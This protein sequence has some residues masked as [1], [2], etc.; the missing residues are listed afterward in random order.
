[1][2]RPTPLSRPA[3]TSCSKLPPHHGESPTTTGIGL[4]AGRKRRVERGGERRCG[5]RS[6][7]CSAS[8]RMPG[9]VGRRRARHGPYRRAQGPR[10][11]QGADRLHRRHQHGRRGGGALCE[12][13]DRK[14]NRRHHAFA[15]LAGRLSRCAPTP[16]SRLQAQ[17]GRPQFP[18][19]CAPGLE[20]R[21]FTS[22]Q[23][24]HPRPTIAGD[25]AAADLAIHRQ[26]EF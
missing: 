7:L 24:V 1:M 10:G 5:D 2:P 23:G 20:A 17:A 14:R 26:R 22:A 18:G 15:R 3:S 9:I 25:P 12:R 4:R 6:S 21:A 13:Y 19:A 11:T 16:R 8:A